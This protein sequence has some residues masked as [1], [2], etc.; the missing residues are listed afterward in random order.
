MAGWSGRQ[1]RPPLCSQFC[2]HTTAPCAGHSLIEGAA[3]S[4]PCLS[5]PSHRRP[6][7][8]PRNLWRRQTRCQA[9]TRGRSERPL[10]LYIIFTQRQTESSCYCQGQGGVP[11]N[12]TAKRTP[13]LRVAGRTGAWQGTRPRQL[14]NTVELKRPPL[15][16]TPPGEKPTPSLLKSHNGDVPC[17]SHNESQFRNQKTNLYQAID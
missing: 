8:S 2:S 7:A 13:V 9:A 3:C 14:P 1:A 15:L 11:R 16:P 12:E 6:A 10:R 17:P 5:P 4:T